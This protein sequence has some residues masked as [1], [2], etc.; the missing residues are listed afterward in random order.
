MQ[1][2]TFITGNTGKASQLSKYLGIPVNHQKLDLD[3]IQSL[4]L[5]EVIEHKV[6]QAY[7]IIQKPVIVDDTSLTINCLG[8]LPGPFIKFFLKEMGGDNLCKIAHIFSDTTAVAEV[9]IGLF[10]GKNLSI[11]KGEIKGKISK[12]AKGE[13][14]FGWDCLFI[15]EGFD[16]TRAEMNEKD[17][18][19][20]SPRRMALKKLER[21]LKN[22]G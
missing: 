12:K 9:A 2:L 15:P 16:K 10:D 8:K 7:L 3:E 4:N 18:N 17:Y 22:A 6:K 20:T 13:R 21:Y 11:F 14:G 1:G 19:L 5:E